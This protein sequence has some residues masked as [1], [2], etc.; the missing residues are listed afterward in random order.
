[1]TGAISFLQHALEICDSREVCSGCPCEAI[2]RCRKSLSRVPADEL[3]GIVRNVEAVAR[4]L[5]AEK[6]ARSDH[7]G[8]KIYVSRYD[9]Y[10]GGVVME[11]QCVAPREVDAFLSEKCKL[12]LQRACL[13]EKDLVHKD[14]YTARWEDGRFS[15]FLQLT[16]GDVDPVSDRLGEFDADGKLKAEKYNAFLAVNLKNPYLEH[17]DELYRF[18]PETVL[19]IHE[20]TFPCGPGV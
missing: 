12:E 5:D 2:C 11:H 9:T 18:V 1:M 13:T 17:Y 15:V 7:H 3:A 10:S 19:K 20:G 8:K 16:R 6:T 14:E 4:A